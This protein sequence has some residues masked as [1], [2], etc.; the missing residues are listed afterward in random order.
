MKAILLI[1]LGCCFIGCGSM[2]SS[3]NVS[4]NDGKKHILPPD[5]P[6]NKYSKTRQGG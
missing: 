3:Q 1:I 5:T 2:K 6:S 4:N